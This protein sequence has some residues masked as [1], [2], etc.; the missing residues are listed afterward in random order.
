MPEHGIDILVKFVET[1]KDRTIA[2][3]IVWTNEGG[4]MNQLNYRYVRLGIV[5]EEDED[6]SVYLPKSH[7][8]DREW[9]L[10]NDIYCLK[11]FQKGK[12]L[13]VV[14]YTTESLKGYKAFDFILVCNDNAKERWELMFGT[15]QDAFEGLRDKAEELVAILDGFEF[16]PIL[17]KEHRNFIEAF[18]KEDD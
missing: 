11:D 15:A 2:N 17:T 6:V 5:S 3:E 14:A 4:Y 16:Q 18:L 1:L 7:D 8:S 13:V 10:S 9:V 12:D